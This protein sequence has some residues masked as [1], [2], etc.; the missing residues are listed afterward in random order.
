[1]AARILVVD[2]DPSVCRLLETELGRCGF[3][4]WAVASAA[5]ALRQLDLL[6]PDVLLT[7]VI[8]EGMDGLQLCGQ[9]VSHRPDVPVVVM[10]A[11]E[12]PDTAIGAIHAGA[13]D[14]ITKPID[15]EVLGT[16][17]R[18][19]AQHRGLVATVERLR[20]AVGDTPRFDEL[21]GTSAAMR[22]VY[23]LLER[24]AESDASV[25]ITGESG[26]GKELVALALHR[27][28]RRAKGP[29][30]AVDCS[31]IP[32]G[33]LESELF[34]HTRGAFTDARAD[35]VGL[36]AQA[37]GGTLL[38]DEIGNLPL[39]LQ[40]KLLRALQERTVRPVGGQAE[41]PFDVRIVAATNR[42]LPTAVKEER[43]R[44]DLFSRI[45]VIHVQMPPLREREDDVLLLAQS[46]VE[47]AALRAGKQI[48][49]L[50]PGAV[51]RLQAH[52]WPGNVRELQNCIERAVA[53][54]TRDEIAAADL[55]EHLRS[56]LRAPASTPDEA[57]LAPLAEIERL[58]ILGVLDAVRGNRSRAANI[59]GIDRK[60][61]QRRL[62]RFAAEPR[63]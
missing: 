31:A 2:N 27:K 22:R 30:V 11:S 45:A 23:A 62:E 15:F 33:L 32:E 36:F 16:V 43:F 54:A 39:G 4:A 37:S 19:A 42:D 52:A 34:G 51:A 60:T 8:M 63:G 38:L 10:T 6:E 53:L 18:R 47:R 29:F 14:F 12:R 40:P 50:A 21:V 1:M 9:V 5:E 28:G 20:R 46:F 48:R 3:E 26:T 59:L 61:L 24:V 55:P 35:R 49:G 57:A 13:Y 56:T 17:L 58:H 7:D 41:V 44:Q 25:L